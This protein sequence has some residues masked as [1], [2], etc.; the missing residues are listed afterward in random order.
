MNVPPAVMQWR[1]LAE[2]YAALNP[3]LTAN[4]VLAI[5]WS[6]STGDPNAENPH[7]PSYGLMQVTLSI[8]RYFGDVTSSDEL[9]DPETN[10]RAG[11]G[12]LAHLKNAYGKQF[13]DS[14]PIGYNEGEGN[15]RRGRQ[16]PDYLA[17]FNAHM[18]ALSELENS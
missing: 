3:P 9:F 5:I 1:Q 4:E 15:L 7:D 17:A 2:K 12:F 10:V 14:W 6:E 16:D 11:A 13:P 8:G 18:V